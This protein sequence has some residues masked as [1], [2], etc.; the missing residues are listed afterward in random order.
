MEKRIN[1]S[2]EREKKKKRI[3]KKMILS[4]Q[5]PR[6]CVFKSSKHIYAN[7]VDDLKGK[8]LAC[9]STL[10]KDLKG[11]LKGLDKKAR[12]AKVG[13]LIAKYAMEKKITKVV[14]DRSGYV[15]HGRIKALAD[16]ARKVGLKF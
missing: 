1:K 10:S 13:E 11:N 15:Y 9:A 7:L 14:F 4:S 6:L 3:K 8:T 2:K 12:A 5:R 16:A